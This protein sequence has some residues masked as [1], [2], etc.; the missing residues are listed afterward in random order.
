MIVLAISDGD[1]NIEVSKNR[2]NI[3][4][5]IN[6]YLYIQYTDIHIYRYRYI[7]AG[8]L[9][10]SIHASLYITLARRTKTEKEKERKG[11]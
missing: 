10:G 1:F 4:K 11:E 7:T 9:R 3:H 8:K 2:T 5:Y 6:I